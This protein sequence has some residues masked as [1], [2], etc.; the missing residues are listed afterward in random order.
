MCYPFDRLIIK[1]IVI[2][3]VLLARGSI[4]YMW[5]KHASNDSGTFIMLPDELISIMRNEN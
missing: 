5:L 3:N 2:G 4:S 1:F